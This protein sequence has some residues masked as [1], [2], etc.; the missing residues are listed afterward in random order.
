MQ[1]ERPPWCICHE[2]FYTR[3]DRAGRPLLDP[4]CRH[5][6]IE[7]YEARIADLEERRRL[8]KRLYAQ[9]MV[10]SRQDADDIT[11]LQDANQH[12]V[13]EI[14]KLVAEVDYLQQE[15]M[16][17]QVGEPYQVGWEHGCA[18]AIKAV[19]QARDEAQEWKKS[20]EAAEAH[21]IALEN[22]L[23]R[24]RQYMK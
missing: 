8:L 19:D 7:D 11:E 12:L 10:A 1:C 24:L 16:R 6:E 13:A 22:E 15:L 17:Y 18:S 14:R 5:D 2:S 4:A 23:D 20:A 21:V 9:H 3:H